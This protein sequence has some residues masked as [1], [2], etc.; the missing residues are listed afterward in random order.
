MSRLSQRYVAYQ[1][2]D[3]DH[4]YADQDSVYVEDRKCPMCFRRCSK[5]KPSTKSMVTLGN[6]KTTSV[7]LC[8]KPCCC[9]CCT[10][11]CLIRGAI[12]TLSVL[13]LLAIITLLLWIYALPG[14]IGMYLK[15]TNITFDYVS[16]SD[17]LPDGTKS[18]DSLIMSGEAR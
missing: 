15:A 14:W 18:T 6:K 17:N 3:D 12:I 16:M 13:T 8:C 9:G 11:C 7:K 2:N 10:R 4:D 5:R 1:D